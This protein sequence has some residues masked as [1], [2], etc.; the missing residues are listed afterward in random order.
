MREPTSALD[1]LLESET[2]IGHFTLHPLTIQRVA[3]LE[4]LESPFIISTAKQPTAFDVMA[5]CWVMTS[6]T[7]ELRNAKSSRI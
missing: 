1:A 5:I 6:S 7:A 2:T 3:V 4:L